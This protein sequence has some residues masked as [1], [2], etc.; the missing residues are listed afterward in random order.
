MLMKKLE[1]QGLASISG[2]AC[3]RKWKNSRYFSL[4]T[5]KVAEMG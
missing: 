5:G 1:E 3:I 2:R 4:K